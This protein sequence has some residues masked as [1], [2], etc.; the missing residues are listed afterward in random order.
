MSSWMLLYIFQFSKHTH[1]FKTR[2]LVADHMGDCC[3]I[4]LLFSYLFIFESIVVFCPFITIIFSFL[5]Y[6]TKC[7][8]HIF[9]CKLVVNIKNWVDMNEYKYVCIKLVHACWENW[10]YA[11]TMQLFISLHMYN[12]FLGWYLVPNNLQKPY[13]KPYLPNSFW[14]AEKEG[15]ETKAFTRHVR[16][17]FHLSLKL[18]PWMIQHFSPF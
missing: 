17:A 15:W 12:I 11:L 9:I 3:M 7:N 5:C 1:V 16:T 4:K 14:Q 8:V 18:A 10:Q 6:L 13:G 2:I